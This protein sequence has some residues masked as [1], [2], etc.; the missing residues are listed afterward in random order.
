MKGIPHLMRNLLTVRDYFNGFG[1]SQSKEGDDVSTVL[2]V[3]TMI[4]NVC[5]LKLRNI[6]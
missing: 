6:V 3:M 5:N 4:P 1:C 2:L